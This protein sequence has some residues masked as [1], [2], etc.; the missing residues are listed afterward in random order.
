MGVERRKPRSPGLAGSRLIAA[1]AERVDPPLRPLAIGVLA[2]GLLAI[3]TGAILVEAAREA[4]AIAKAAWRTSI[5][6]AILAVPVAFDR[7]HRRALLGLDRRHRVHLAGAGIALAAHFA[8]WIPSLDYTSVASSVVLVTMSPLFVA[9]L[10]GRI[11][12]E[13][14]AGATW[15]GVGLALVGSIVVGWGDA[16]LGGRALLGDA[17]ALGGAV[18]AAV[19]FVFGR[20]ARRRLDLVPYVAA[21]YS[22]A[23]LFL[24]AL[25]LAR[26]DRLI[27]FTP[28]TWALLLLLAIVPQV[29][30]HT[31][32]NWAL[33]SLSAAFVAVVTLG[34]PIVSSGLAWLIFDE[35]P[36]ARTLLGGGLILSGLYV[37]SRGEHRHRARPADPP[38]V[39]EG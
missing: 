34:E 21:V 20:V 6:G 27:G 3:S 30:G 25:A 35:V 13:Q 31:S 11:L 36:T 18:A 2:I 16:A 37:A 23:G 24:F 8:L 9:L 33:A 19:Y 29:I 39:V 10:T 22:I 28:A 1:P 15:R 7:R 14:V 38:R 12:G 26:G 32:L 5:A 4:P 17:L